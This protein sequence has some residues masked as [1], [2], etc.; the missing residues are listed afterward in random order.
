MNELEIR[1]KLTALYEVMLERSED[2]RKNVTADD[3]FTAA[4][5]I[6]ISIDLLTLAIKEKK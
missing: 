4:E 1:Q 5:R 3:L 2:T 6:S